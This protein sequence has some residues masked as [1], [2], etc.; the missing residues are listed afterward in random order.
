MQF[1]IKLYALYKICKI[2]LNSSYTS[3]H[4]LI[5]PFTHSPP[6]RPR[7]PEAA[8]GW[9]RPAVVCNKL[10]GVDFFHT[11]NSR[12]RSFLQMTNRKSTQSEFWLSV[13]ALMCLLML[14]ALPNWFHSVSD[15]QI[16]LTSSSSVH[17]NWERKAWAGR[18]ESGE[19]W[20]NETLGLGVNWA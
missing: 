14:P 13:T 16:T 15:L 19:S 3:C 17:S 6:P 11:D 1:Y 10:Y 5:P 8:V 20:A 2:S 7:L 12:T 18:G 9:C 4:I